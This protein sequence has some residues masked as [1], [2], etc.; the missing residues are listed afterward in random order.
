MKERRWIRWIWNFHKCWKYVRKVL[1]SCWNLAREVLKLC[2]KGTE[3]AEFKIFT[4]AEIM[5]ERSWIKCWF[6]ARN[7]N[8]MLILCKKFFIS[9]DSA[10]FFLFSAQ[11]AQ[12]L[13]KFSTFKGFLTKLSAD[14]CWP[15]DPGNLNRDDQKE[16]VLYLE[17]VNEQVVSGFR[18]K[19]FV[20]IDKYLS[21]YQNPDNMLSVL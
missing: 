4:C 1:R 11:S 5:Y 14:S 17:T 16:E 19:Y 2:K 6:Y 3:S 20:A 8:Q 21:M 9:A 13:H 18:S 12:A 10:P 15:L 7:M